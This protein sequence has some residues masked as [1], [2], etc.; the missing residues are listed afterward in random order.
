MADRFEKQVTLLDSVISDG[1]AASAN[2]A[3]TFTQA[4]RALYVGGAGD[5]EVQML[6]YNQSNTVLKFAGVPAGTVLP[7]RA[8][9]LTGN[10]TATDVVGL[11]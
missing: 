6:T 1:F 5:V 4:T 9:A 7:I 2:S 3:N 10:T 11:F 8:V